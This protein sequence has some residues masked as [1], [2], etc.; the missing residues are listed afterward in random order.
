MN[1]NL[2]CIYRLAVKFG[3]N[4]VKFHASY[5]DYSDRNNFNQVSMQQYFD[6]AQLRKRSEY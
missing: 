1:S 4:K 3:P 5:S 6:M 2:K